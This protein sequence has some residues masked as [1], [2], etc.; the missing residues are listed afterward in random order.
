MEKGGI[1]GLSM[2]VVPIFA[3]I[4]GGKSSSGLVLLLFMLAD[5]VAI[6]YYFQSVRWDILWKILPATIVGIFLGTILGNYIDDELYKGLIAI[7]L[8]LCLA[9]M[10]F[11]SYSGQFKPSLENNSAMGITGILTGFSTM[12]AN[13]SSPILAIYLL[14][15]HLR[16]LE[17]IGTIVWF[18]F[19]VNIIKLPFHIW[20]WQTIE[21]PTFYAALHGILPIALGFFLGAFLIKRLLEQ[22]FR[23]LIIMVTLI[24]ALRLLF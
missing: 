12:I 17:F 10:L 16:K 5:L 9:A 18:F 14:S 24:A 22:H 1:K 23:I 15:I 6:R 13:V 21:L 20:I 19:I 2:I 7:V 4:L 8:L 11:Q 3:V